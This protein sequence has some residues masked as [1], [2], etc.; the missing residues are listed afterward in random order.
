MRDYFNLSAFNIFYI[1]NS[2]EIRVGVGQW[3][4]CAI[5]TGIFSGGKKLQL[6]R[7]ERLSKKL[8]VN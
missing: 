4:G 3:K 8:F 6:K 1:L 5:M 2:E 7:N